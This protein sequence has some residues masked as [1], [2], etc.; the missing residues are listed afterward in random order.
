V[1]ANLSL[2]AQTVTCGAL[3]T[4]NGTNFGSPPSSAGTQVNLIGPGTEGTHALTIT[5]GSNTSL[6]VQVPTTG[7]QPGPH[8]LTVTNNQG[9]AQAA[10]T[11]A[12]PGCP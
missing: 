7:I 5:A 3:L 2:S 8:T 4:I 10:I 1:P 6:L 9:F 11:I 12:A